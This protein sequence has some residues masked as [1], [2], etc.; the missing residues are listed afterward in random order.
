MRGLLGFASFFC[1]L[2]VLITGLVTWGYYFYF[3]PNLTNPET[4][5]RVEAYLTD[6]QAPLAGIRSVALDC[7]RVFLQSHETLDL[8]FQFLLI[9]TVVGA[10]GFAYLAINIYRFRKGATRAL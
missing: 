4:L 1:G 2:F 3:R 7:H 9:M 10:V 6:P 8:A 5:R